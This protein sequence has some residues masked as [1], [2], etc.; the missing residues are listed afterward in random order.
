VA[1]DDIA[2]WCALLAAAL[3]ETDGP[4][5][6]EERPGRRDTTDGW[7]ALPA[8]AWKIGARVVVTSDPG[9]PRRLDPRVT[10]LIV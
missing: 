10:L 7:V 9:D 2:G 3:R 1:L 4:P 8:R 6:D 5:S